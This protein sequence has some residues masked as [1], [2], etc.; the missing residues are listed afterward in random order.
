MLI[1]STPPPQKKYAAVA[2]NIEKY[3]N[4]AYKIKAIGLSIRDKYNPEKDNISKN[5]S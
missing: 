1:V 2:Q 3:F 5:K 4:P